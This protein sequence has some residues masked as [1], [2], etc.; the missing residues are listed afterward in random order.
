MDCLS[1]KIDNLYYGTIEMEIAEYYNM[2]SP[3]NS[4][5]P[6]EMSENEFGNYILICTKA[7]GEFSIRITKQP[8]KKYWLFVSPIGKINY[9]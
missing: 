1:V 9:D 5:I 7:S 6:P 4:S 3:D 8:D 2:G